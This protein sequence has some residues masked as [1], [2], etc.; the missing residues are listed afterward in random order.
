MAILKLIFLFKEVILRF[1]VNFLGCIYT[2]YN[3]LYLLRY[4]EWTSQEKKKKN[5]QTVFQVALAY[6]RQ[7]GCLG[8][9]SRITGAL[10][11]TSLGS[12]PRPGVAEFPSP[13]GPSF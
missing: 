5:L 7:G 3:P 8:S 1:H 2:G 11:W 10:F 13:S 4:H 6:H 9:R 12:K